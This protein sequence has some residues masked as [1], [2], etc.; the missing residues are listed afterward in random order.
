MVRTWGA[1]KKQPE[2][3]EKSMFNLVANSVVQI[4]KQVGKGNA[5]KHGQWNGGDFGQ[6][7][8]EFLFEPL[9]E[10][11]YSPGGV[12]PSETPESDF[13][14]PRMNGNGKGGQDYLSAGEKRKDERVVTWCHRMRNTRDHT[15]VKTLMKVLGIGRVDVVERKLTGMSARSRA[16]SEKDVGESEKHEMTLQ[17]KVIAE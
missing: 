14:T 13:S 2:Y 15:E 16:E 17:E 6:V 1:G 4:V 5:L 7:G 11:D 8:G 12:S 10:K 3:I 9:H